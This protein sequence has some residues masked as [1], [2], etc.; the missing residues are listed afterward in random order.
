MA[1][2]KLIHL[3]AGNKAGKP[4]ASAIDFGEIAV[5]YTAGSEKLYIKNNASDPKVIGF[6][7]DNDPRLTNARPANGGTS[8]VSRKVDTPTLTNINSAFSEGYTTFNKLTATS[9]NLAGDAN[10][11]PVSNNANG[12]ITIHTHPGN[13][14]GQLG[15]S[16]NERLYYK[17]TN[18]TL[19]TG[20]DKWKK[21]AFTSDIP[22][23]SITDTGSGNVITN[24]QASGHKLTV[25]RA[26]HDEKYMPLY[27]STLYLDNGDSSWG[28]KIDF[29]KDDKGYVFLHED[30][31][32]H[33]RIHGNQGVNITSSDPDT[34]KANNKRILTDGNIG[35][36]TAY[37]T[38]RD[39]ELGMLIK[40]SID[41]SVASGAPF[42]MEIKGNTYGNKNSSFLQVQGYI[43]DNTL[44]QYGMTNLGFHRFEKLIAMNIDGK[45]CFWTPR[46]TYWEGFS[47]FCCECGANYR[48]YN[49]NLVT[50]VEDCAE[51]N[52]T[53]K[54]NIHTQIKNSA[55]TN[56]IPTIPNKLPADGGIADIAKKVQDYGD[57]SK[58]LYIGYA[59][60]GIS[61]TSSFAAY[62]THNGSNAIKDISVADTKKV[63]GIPENPKYTD[64]HWTTG[65]SA[66][67][68]GVC[69]NASVTNPYIK[70]CDSGTY[71]SQIRLNGSKDLTINSDASGNINFSVTNMRYTHPGKPS[72]GNDAASTGTTGNQTTYVTNVNIDGNGHV[73]SVDKGSL[74]SKMAPTSH[75]H[76]WSEID[77]KP[78][79]ATRWPGWDEVTE[80]PDTFAPSDHS[81]PYLPL[82]GGTIT[83][84]IEVSKFV[85]IKGVETIGGGLYVGDGLDLSNKIFIQNIPNIPASIG[86]SKNIEITSGPYCKMNIN[87]TGEIVFTC[88]NG[89]K[90]D[91]G[92]FD[93]SDERLKNF[94]ED[95]N[96]DF[97]KL[98]TI[99]KKYFTWKDEKMGTD[100]QIGTSA[101]EVQKIYPELIK[102]DEKGKLSVSY[103]KLSIVALK[104]VDELHDE[105]E[106]LKNELD[107]LKSEIDMIKIKLG[108]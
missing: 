7:N 30:S 19:K 105:N 54:V 47:V 33:L 35:E 39:F 9:G 78:A 37:T 32:D 8:T 92:F 5:N 29:C 27:P 52:G 87:N 36:Y 48:N 4:A 88:S 67:N 13:Y 101:Q 23:I 15:F 41:Y 49:E 59:S 84:H 22:S 24:I 28:A 40:T 82:T 103:E 62:T 65:I 95:I 14:F 25:S 91:G 99:P 51:P 43:Y 21:I 6:V 46:R 94:K 38:E 18:G 98:K 10:G 20:S 45:L 42:Y 3:H 71:R 17:F 58:S 97:N 60:N 57:T 102:S 81:H 89:V 75:R 72:S 70:V 106:R 61:T 79:T 96:V 69:G 107:S 56:E 31:S 55:F 83:G 64:T 53:K 85:E 73:A 77:S 74:P 86:C 104:A 68:S 63:L 16:S 100:L 50:S 44:I 76:G 66:G 12:L 108:L 26:N 1:R 80:K 93:T 11:F 34:V 90:S 2:Q